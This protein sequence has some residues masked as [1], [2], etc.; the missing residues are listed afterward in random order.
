MGCGSGVV[1]ADFG[2]RFG[3]GSRGGGSGGGVVG[4]GEGNLGDHFLVGHGAGAQKQIRVVKCL[5]GVV[6]LML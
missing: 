1:D 6:R 2:V 3:F 5:Q 4:G